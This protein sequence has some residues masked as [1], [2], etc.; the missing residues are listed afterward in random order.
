MHATL[1]PH[2][3]LLESL[4]SG[5]NG[6]K[7]LHGCI[8]SGPRGI[9]KAGL[10][11]ALAFR[12]LDV[13]ADAAPDA[14]HPDLV[15]VE[16]DEE[17][18]TKTIGVDQVRAACRLIR[19]TPA[20]GGRRI[21]VIDSGDDLTEPAANALLKTLEEPPVDASVIIV[22]HT[23]SRLPTTIR[24]RCSLVRVPTPPV[25]TA[26][27]ALRRLH[28]E[29]DEAG[30]RALVVLA[31]GSPGL[32]ADFV[33]GDA[34]KAYASVVEIFTRTIENGG[35]LDRLAA[36][37]FADA[38]AKDEAWGVAS[39]MVACLVQRATE[40]AAGVAP[41]PAVDG[42]AA[43]LEGLAQQAGLTGLST[44]SRIVDRT[45]EETNLRH[46]DRRYAMIRLLLAVEFGLKSGTRAAGR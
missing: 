45:I 39:R 18:A 23:A 6:G 7:S 4:V 26:V 44:A 10:A 3:D 46:L 2:A 30:A 20:R 8:L 16:P 36:N 37:A 17:S 24:S 12:L 34:L 14:M 42:E 27:A 28:P 25:E 43:L 21:C 9:G 11:R 29:L 32:A 38:H 13:P 5:W 22:A 40:T 15:W 19:M 1:V 41:D 35:V 31:D 33:Q